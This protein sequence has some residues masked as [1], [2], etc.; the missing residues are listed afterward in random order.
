M[1]AASEDQARCTA[2]QSSLFVGR[3]AV[4]EL[5][6]GTEY[7]TVEPQSTSFIF[8]C[9]NVLSVCVYTQCAC[10]LLVEASSVNIKI[11]PLGI[12]LKMAVT[13]TYGAQ[14]L[15]ECS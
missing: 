14:V 1:W 9:M 6:A 12:E 8:M 5:A 11:D 10:L 15:W 7:L 13:V 2:L 4:T 3:C